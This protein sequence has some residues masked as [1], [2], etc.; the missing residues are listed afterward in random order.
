MTANQILIGVG[1]MSSARRLATPFTY[2]SA[3]P[4]PLSGSSVNTGPVGG[5]VDH[6]PPA[7]GG[8]GQDLVG[9]AAQDRITVV[10]VL[11]LAVG[12]A[13]DQFQRPVRADGG[14]LEHGQVAVGVPGGAVLSTT[15]RHCRTPRHGPT[16]GR[17]PASQ[18]RS[19]RR[20]T[21]RLTASRVSHASPAVDR[22]S[23][24]TY[25]LRAGKFVR[26][27]SKATHGSQPLRG[28]GAA[29]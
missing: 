10:G 21:P 4:V 12:V 9:A 13:D 17:S 2:A 1:M 6:G 16:P 8:G 11:P 20:R 5:H 7:L 26:C 29:P 24:C 3:A 14:P 27:A 18:D 22:R 15:C 19:R 25:T 28:P 23:C